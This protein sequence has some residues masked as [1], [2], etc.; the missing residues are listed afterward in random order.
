MKQN[1]TK[2][3]I[4]RVMEHGIGFWSG[5]IL[6]LA[7]LLL[8]LLICVEKSYADEISIKQFD[9]EK[10]TTAF[11]K[12][13]EG[14]IWIGTL[15]GL[16]IRFDGYDQVTYNL[17]GGNIQHI[18]EDEEGNLWIFVDNKGL[19]KLN[20]RTDSLSTF[21]TDQGLSSDGITISNA[22]LAFDNEKNLWIGTKDG[23]NRFNPGTESFTV[24][25][26]DSSNSN[27]LSNNEIYAVAKGP[28]NTIW[29]GTG[30]GLSVFH[31]ETRTFD[32]YRFGQENAD[33]TLVS[34]IYLDKGIAWLGCDAGILVRF[35]PQSGET[36]SY[37]VKDMA[38]RI[39]GIQPYKGE[40]LLYSNLGVKV[41]RFDPEEKTSSLF[42]EKVG[43]HAI[44][45]S[46]RDGLWG[47]GINT[48]FKEEVPK[49]M[50]FPIDPEGKNTLKNEKVF[51]LLI[52][53]EGIL[54]Y[55]YITHGLGSYDPRTGRH[56]HYGFDPKDPEKASYSYVSGLYEAEDGELWVGTY[57]GALGIFDRES[58]HFVYHDH[59]IKPI[60]SIVEDP[61][62]SDIFWMTGWQSGFWKYDRRKKEILGHYRHE[63]GKPNSPAGSSSLSL[64]K[65]PETALL[66]IAYYDGGV[67]RFDPATETFTNY[68]HNPEDTASLSHNA[69]NSV[70]QD[71][72]GSVWAATNDGINKIDRN[73]GVIRRFTRANGF[74]A[75]IAF[76]MEE[77]DGCLWVATDKGVIKFSLT[78]ESVEKVYTKSDGLRSHAFFGS[79]HTNSSD[80][81]IY[82]GGFKGVNFFYPGNIRENTTPPPVVVTSLTQA[83]EPI[84][85][86]VRTDFADTITL[87]WNENFFE[88][89]YVA[90]NYENQDRNRYLYKLEG[91][92]NDWYDAENQRKGRYSGLPGGKYLLRI[93]GS[94]NDGVWCN[95]EDEVALTVIV[96]APFWKTWWF[97]T[98]CIAAVLGFTGYIFRSQRNKLRHQR[99]TAEKLR[100][101]DRLK[102]E[103]M[104]NTSHELRTPLNGIVGIAESLIDGAAGPLS[105]VMIR[106]LSM[107]ASSGRRLTNLVNDILDFSKLRHHELQLRT[108]P[109]DMRSVTDVILMLSQTLV[110]NREIQLV[111]Q[112]EP[113]IPGVLA[114][115]NRVQQ[116]L[117]NLVGNAVKF[118]ETG[119]VSVS[120]E[121]R[122]EHLAVTVSDTGIGIPEEKLESI[123]RSFEQADGST[124]REYGGTGLGLAVTKQLTELHGGQIL[125]ESEPGKGSRFTFTLPVSGDKAEPARAAGIIERDTR[126]AGISAEP[127]ETEQTGEPDIANIPPENL[128]KG[129][130]CRILVVDDEPV[131]LQ[132]LKNQLASGYYSVTPASGG[133]E[134][135][136]AVESGQ[137]FDLVLLDVMMPGMS[138]YE[139]CRHLR[140]RYKPDE[141]PV[142]ML[143]AK[144]RVEDLVAGFDA[145]ANDYLAKPFMKDELLARVESHIE[146]K[147]L[148]AQV[149][150]LVENLE[151]RVAERTLQLQESL[152]N[153]RK[154]QDHLVQSEKM[155]ALGGLVAGV[156]HEINT[157]VGIG[158]SEASFLKEETKG[159]SESYSSGSLKRSDFEEYIKDATESATSILTNLGRAADLIASF[160]QV[161]AD[162]SSDERRRFALKPYIREIL[163]SLSPKFKKTSHAI[164]LNCPEDLEIDSFPGA[165][166]QI[167]TN[168]V[169]NSLLH[170][171]EGIE[172]GEIRFDATTKGEELLFRYSDN[173]RGMNEESV[174]Q[175]FDPFFTTKRTSGG[176]G[177][178][179]HIVFNL[180]TQTLGGEIKCDSTLGEGTSFLIRMKAEDPGS[181]IM[182]LDA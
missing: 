5:K 21:G 101:L 138:G 47:A 174:G 19:V 170:G 33:S 81:W 42:M 122:D 1:K 24:F 71:S 43:I 165:F 14:F 143:T 124:E 96:G 35:D 57:G 29:I 156:A 178:G 20:K 176:T 36:V 160:K 163:V 18:I 63:D 66:W 149:R 110:G 161:A 169:T 150:D 64:I 123:F 30:D 9:I 53:R 109:L 140:E 58:G 145:G 127:A 37:P 162:Q 153:L 48:I 151:H 39:L 167:I 129:K 132:V 82:F 87:P 83:G 11:L 68:S 116:I 164:T 112:I 4:S 41:Y 173:G 104:A 6:F 105:E 93:R 131:N 171:F 86:Q 117:H 182:R 62:N 121:V 139:V 88:F 8:H 106:N 175:V 102:D 22:L 159:F 65:D 34:S 157:P 80:G 40:L 56:T 158:I 2:S 141:L 100:R 92:D 28:D 31:T 133:K 125:A 78:T 99:E 166:S 142:V 50:N 152:E 95:P 70:F 154:A 115:E 12:D 7:F 146:M 17:K 49:F 25:R 107:V 79:S 111:N 32:V 126:V 147:S 89:E 91:F 130:L 85:L 181:G 59:R 168:F 23:L 97:Y 77:V 72:H 10:G 136:D 128:C 61:H 16:L 44:S 114:D 119:T 27:S 155:A 90:L 13:Q 84:P 67:S 144:N 73:S 180:V 98:F 118:T 60:Y 137:K 54:W 148:A 45:V 51:P 52:D 15:N 179:M 69:V 103:F 26:H 76:C 172:S 46:E 74:P 3:I 120:A 177:L 134:A 108:K 55:G 94:N 38:A 135:L 113:D 75:D